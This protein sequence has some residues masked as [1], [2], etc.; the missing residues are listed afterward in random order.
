MSLHGGAQQ[1]SYL[2]EHPY[3]TDTVLPGL[4]KRILPDDTYRELT[5]DLVRLGN[6]LVD[7]IRPLAALVQPP[8]LAQYDQHG[9]RAD[10]VD[11]SHGR[12]LFQKF[13]LQEG[14][15]AVAYER[16]Y[17]QHSRT[18]QFA[19]T[20]VMTGDCHTIMCP[21]G[22]SDGGARLIELHG[23][24][25]MK[26]ELLPRVRS[27]DPLTACIADQWISESAGGSDISLT[28]TRAVPTQ[29]V[30]TDLGDPYLLNGIKWLTCAA[31][32]NIAVA[33]A[34]TGDAPHGVHGLSLFI[35]PLRLAP[36]V[37]SAPLRNGVKIRSIKDKVGTRDVATA[38]LE[39][40]DT[41]GWLIGPL[42]EGPQCIP[43]MLNITR[44]H[45]AIHSVGSLQRCLAIAR[46]YAG[47]RAIHGG[48]T[49]LKDVPIHVA[50]LADIALL[51]RA[52]TH[53]TF[54]VVAL[55]GKSECGTASVQEE[56]RLKLLLPTVKAYAAEHATGAMEQAMASLGSVGYM[57]ETGIGRLIRDA[58][59]EKIW[60]GTYN[61]CS[62]DLL[63]TATKVPQSVAHFASWGS[64]ILSAVPIQLAQEAHSA[65]GALSSALRSLPTYIQDQARTRNPLLPRP[66]LDYFA[67]ISC[68][69]YLLEHA[70]WSCRNCEATR[71]VDVEA[72]RR[73]MERGDLAKAEGSIRAL[74][75]DSSRR[76][77]M[78]SQLVFGPEAAVAKL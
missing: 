56:S 52:L 14:Y 72:F 11:T 57:E 30:D 26:R 36:H 58:M 24:N 40:H 73:W 3:N 42:H 51:Y 71:E 23:T 47:V 45:S 76:V 64:G 16:R 38:E 43:L 19:R 32:G 29:R 31:E 67:I 54:G 60:E 7:E 12:A 20:M 10:V 68:A 49:L 62:L 18:Y 21:M 6:I 55:L 8:T 53:L 65:I 77:Q 5:R 37:E 15:N 70:T 78:N 48:K 69:L 39:L 63:R 28:Q 17:G 50:G 13:A 25:T 41:R 33:L 44:V 74:R 35:V 61:M 2:S 34:R 46:S 1:A 75:G 59:V 4:L 27:R 22:M 9:Q 66:L